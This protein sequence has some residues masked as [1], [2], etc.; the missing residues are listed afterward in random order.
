MC[1][2]AVVLF[3]LV[4]HFVSRLPLNGNENS[5]ASLAGCSNSILISWQWHFLLYYL[6][7]TR[8]LGLDVGLI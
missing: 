2:T 8:L 1:V 6:Y 5:G 4:C 7:I 3:D